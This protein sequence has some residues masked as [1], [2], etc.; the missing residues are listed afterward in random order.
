MIGH[1]DLVV[2]PNAR[3]AL[4]DEESP[5]Y[6]AAALEERWTPAVAWV[7]WR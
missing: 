7:F 4:F 2:K 6:R 1:F 3:G 5:A